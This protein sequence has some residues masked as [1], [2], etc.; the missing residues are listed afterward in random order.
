MLLM[1]LHSSRVRRVV[2]GA[3]LS[4]SGIVIGVA[5]DVEA[6]PTPGLQQVIWPPAAHARAVWQFR[7]PGNRR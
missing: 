4:L 6:E 3:F 2:N 1:I 5:R 7:V